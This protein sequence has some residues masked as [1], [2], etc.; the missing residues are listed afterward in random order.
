MDRS[1]GEQDL[2]LGYRGSN[3]GG[4]ISL[5]ERRA[6]LQQ[7]LVGGYGCHPRTGAGS[8]R[9]TSDFASDDDARKWLIARPAKE[10]VV[11]RRCP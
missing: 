9:P 7:E 3:N 11:R 6:D 2:M 5:H 10:V 8:E 4:G 1:G